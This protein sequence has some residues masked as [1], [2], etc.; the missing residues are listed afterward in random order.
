MDPQSK[1]WSRLENDWCYTPAG[2]QARPQHDCQFVSR[3]NICQEKPEFYITEG[4]Y[5]D[6]SECL[7]EYVRTGGGLIVGGHA[8]WW[9]DRSNQDNR[10][11]LLHHPANTFLTDFGIAFSS[12]YVDYR[13]AKFPIKTGEVPSLKQSFYFFALMRSSGKQYRK[14]DEDLYN[15]F[16]LHMKEMEGEEKFKDLVE[17]NKKHFES[18][19][20]HYHQLLA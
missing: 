8:W 20:K 6:N 19:Q 14:H 12:S 4:H 15:E 10:S 17:L 1:A 5:E 16:Y 18:L 2:R 9:A 3:E 11:C 13:D 7:L